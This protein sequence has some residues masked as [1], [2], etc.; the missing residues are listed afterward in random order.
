MKTQID[1]YNETLQSLLEKGTGAEVSVTTDEMSKAIR[2]SNIAIKVTKESVLTFI[3]IRKANL[4]RLTAVDF[5]KQTV[6]FICFEEDLINI[7]KS[8]EL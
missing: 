1:E 5:K 8:N 2:Y 6:H 7:V 3:P 4:L